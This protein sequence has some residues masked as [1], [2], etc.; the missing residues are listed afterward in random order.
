M[1]RP[2]NT[3]GPRPPR[4]EPASSSSDSFAECRLPRF[5]PPG[6]GFAPAW[7]AAAWRV[8][9][10]WNAIAAAVSHAPTLRSW[11]L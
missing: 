5:L 7:P 6:P 11:P 9:V 4:L 1:Q 10:T 3:Y 8:P 2:P